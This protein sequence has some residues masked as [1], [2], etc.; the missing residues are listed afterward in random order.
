MYCR[1]TFRGMP[2]TS[3]CRNLPNTLV[4]AANPQDHERVLKLEV[5]E[6]DA[7]VQISMDVG[8]IQTAHWCLQLADLMGLLN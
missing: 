4:N 5:K 1:N 8:D 7:C 3:R 6:R 2:A